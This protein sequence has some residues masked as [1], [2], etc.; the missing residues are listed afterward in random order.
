MD[1][2]RPNRL[3]LQPDWPV[4]NSYTNASFEYTR[5]QISGTSLNSITIVLTIAAITR[6]T[7]VCAYCNHHTCTCMAAH[8]PTESSIQS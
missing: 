7:L 6:L 4:S 3:D 5:R 8:L 2:P 1:P